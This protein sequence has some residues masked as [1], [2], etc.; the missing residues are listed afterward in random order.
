VGRNQLSILLRNGLIFDSRVLD[1]GCGVLRA[2]Y[3]LIH[4]LDPDCYFGIEPNR[5][6][7][8]AG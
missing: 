4:F 3:W 7:L 5:V 8:T 6:I 1:V 2:G